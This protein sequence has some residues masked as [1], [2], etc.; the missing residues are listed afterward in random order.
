MRFLQF[1][2][3]AFFLL[4]AG[5]A[6]AAQPAPDISPGE[7]LVDALEKYRS[8]GLRLVYS[9]GLIR[10]RARVIEVPPADA[11]IQAQLDALL[12]PHG[13]QVRLAE[14]DIW[15]VVS[16]D[17]D[18]PL[19][20]APLETTAAEEVIEEILVVSPRHRLVRATATSQNLDTSEIQGIPSIGRDLLRVVNTLP[21]QADNG[22]SVRPRIRGGTEEEVLYILDGARV[23]EPFH[24]KDFLSPFSAFNTNIIDTVDVYRAGFPASFG[25][26]SSAVMEFGVA[27]TDEPLSGVVDVNLLNAAA[28]V[29]GATGDWQWLAS[30]RRGNLDLVFKLFDE[31]Y[32]NPAFHDEL[33]RISHQ[34]D[35]Q[36]TT[37]GLL[38]ISDDITANNPGIGEFGSSH[39]TNTLAWLTWQRQL[40]VRSE[41]ELH[42]DFSRVRSSRDGWLDNPTDAIGSLDEKRDFDVYRL[43]ASYT[44]KLSN[45]FTLRGGIDYEHQRGD[46]SARLLTLYGPLGAPI[47]PGAGLSRILDADRS[48]DM[49]A[50]YSTAVARISDQLELELGVRYD[51]QDID[52]V[53]DN[54]LSPRLQINY[55]LRDNLAVFLNIG[56]YVQH[57]NL[58]E[59]QL[60]DG[61]LELASPQVSDQASI[62]IR[63]SPG[64]SIEAQL[65]LYYKSIDDPQ[66]R[67][68]NLYNRYVLLPELHADRVQ[69]IPER[70]RATGMELSLS[71]S[72]GADLYW[73]A[74]Y[75]LSDVE[76]ELS[77][78]WRPRPWDQHHSLSLGLDWH[79]GRWRF[80]LHAGY[81]TGWATT[82]LIT[83]PG[84]PIS[85]YDSARLRDFASLNVSIARTWQLPSSQLEVYLDISN[86][87]NRNNIGGYDYMLEEDEAW[88]RDPQDLLPLTPVLGVRW[89]W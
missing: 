57:Q 6:A 3:C 36:R 66:P 56:R 42:G 2:I 82:P 20:P 9:N 23:L 11:S 71:G 1:S 79:P 55:A 24:L 74:A 35:T 80:G 83:Q 84:P 12:A 39:Y 41:F 44:Q 34:S 63:L 30:A 51:V 87:S 70:A 18:E 5:W 43:T 78:D 75:V 22:V 62:G 69:V 31:D 7:P 68:D 4:C 60:D 27:E 89:Q 10:P 29:Q 61:L 54:R 76:E 48:G 81:H 85:L 67:F 64:H 19:T 25:N 26:R 15:Y 52:P 72:G 45:R 16:R 13:L 46:F 88:D 65:E 77:D 17:T 14:G 86:L 37:L 73:R 49:V 28:H 58:Y 59:L 40:S 32:G 33:L 38:N 47:Q 50:F 21:G 8:A 53:H